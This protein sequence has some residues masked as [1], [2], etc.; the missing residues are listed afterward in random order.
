[1]TAVSK[2]IPTV[3]NS[4]FTFIEAIASLALLAV[5]LTTILL[6]YNRTVDSV[7]MQTIRQRATAVAQRHMEMLMASLQEPNNIGLPTRDEIDPDFNW[8]LDLSRITI[9]SLPPNKDLSNTIIKATVKV[10]SES[11]ADRQMPSVEL[12]RYFADLIP[13]PGHAVAVPI[14][15]E[16]EEPQWYLELK[17]KLGREPTLDETLRQMFDMGDLPQE[18]AEELD[19]FDPNEL[20]EEIELPL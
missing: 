1:M 3:K 5:M 13:M 16:Y 17:Q 11:S 9:D 7:S 8:Q 18:I 19:M 20:G 4:G 6:A 10:T 2:K 14:T 15:A 12:M